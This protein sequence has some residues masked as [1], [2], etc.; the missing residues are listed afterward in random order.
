MNS[1]H[2]DREILK[3]IMK[4]TFDDEIEWEYKCIQ[5]VDIYVAEA[6]KGFMLEINTGPVE[7]VLNIEKN[8][9]TASITHKYMLRDLLATVR[10]CCG[11]EKP[12]KRSF[13]ETIS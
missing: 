3:G 8:G 4:K 1:D 9:T 12:L 13:L 5:D 10:G 7:P 11:A 6:G 2:L